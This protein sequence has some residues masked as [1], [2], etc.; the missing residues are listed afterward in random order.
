MIHLNNFT[1]LW[2][3]KKA[4]EQVEDIQLRERI[5]KYYRPK[6]HKPKKSV[7]WK[8][9][10]DRVFSEYDRLYYA[11]DKWYVTCITSGIKMKWNDPNCQCWHFI[12]R[13]VLK[14]RYDIIN[15]HP[16]SYTE[17]CILNWH[18]TVYTIQMIHIYWQEKVEAMINDKEI[19]NY[20]QWWYEEK[21]LEWYDFIIKKKN[22][23]SKAWLW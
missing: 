1:K 9:I 5:L 12:S 17:N 2:K 8:D 16:Q 20:S 6:T 11:D 3:T 15:C 21:I 22:E 4:L 14:Y 18:Y 23:I 7:T 19:V 13:W 10:A